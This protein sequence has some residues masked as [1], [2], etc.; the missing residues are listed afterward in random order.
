[1]SGDR[2]GDDRAATGDDGPTESEDRHEEGQRTGQEPGTAEPTEADA[3]EWTFAVDEV[4]PDGVESGGSDPPL[5]PEEIDLEHA[6]FFLLGVAL[7]L[8]L[9]ARVLL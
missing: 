8:G 2:D 1:M 4:G 6:A 9:V 7:F 5:E 3:E